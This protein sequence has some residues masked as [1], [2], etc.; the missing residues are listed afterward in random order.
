M[1]GTEGAGLR[2]RHGFG[3]RAL[4]SLPR[5]T[6][7]VVAL[8]PARWLGWCCQVSG[9]GEGLVAGVA[10]THRWEINLGASSCQGASVFF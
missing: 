2:M 10:L 1:E 7:A 6:S 3:L 9:R 5:E 4:V 8:R